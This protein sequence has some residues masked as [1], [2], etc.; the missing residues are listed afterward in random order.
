MTI[1]FS[2]SEKSSRCQ[3]SFGVLGAYL[4][5]DVKKLRSRRAMV[6]AGSETPFRASKSYRTPLARITQER[7]RGGQSLRSIDILK[8]G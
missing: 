6:R 1:P 2:L 5:T 7:R 4:R 8:R 3:N